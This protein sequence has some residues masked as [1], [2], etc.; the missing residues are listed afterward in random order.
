MSVLRGLLLFLGVAALSNVAAVWALPWVVNAVVMHVI[1]D[2]G[3]AAARQVLSD[4]DAVDR[5]RA[6]Q[7]LARSARNVALM[8]SPVNATSRAVVRPS[9]DLLYTAC[10]FDLSEHPLH[11]HTPVPD[12]YVSVS[13]F[14]A[15]TTNFFARHGGAGGGVAPGGMIDL[16]LAHG[17]IRGGTSGVPVIQAPSTRGVVLFRTLITDRAQL[18]ALRALQAQQSC[19]PSQ[20]VDAR[21]SR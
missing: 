3:E 13:G 1:V 12:G 15:D 4:G 19:T 5:A 20:D 18:T 14:G 2:R 17:A 21:E 9:P 10:V 6:R 16:V 11:L 8:A 7:V